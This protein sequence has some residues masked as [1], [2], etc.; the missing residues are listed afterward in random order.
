MTSPFITIAELR[1]IE[2]VLNMGGGYVLDFND[3]TFA[4]F[5]QEQGIN[6]DAPT[7]RDKGGSKANR[8][9]SFLAQTPPPRSGQLLAALLDYRQSAGGANLPP[10]TLARALAI[11][12]R[13]GGRAP[14]SLRTKPQE[15]L[16]E[17][18]LLTIVFQP[19]V[20][21]RLPGEP[22]LHA[23]LIARMHEAQRCVTHEAWL[24]AVIL[25][26]SV[27]EGLALGFGHAKPERVNRAYTEQFNKPAP[28]LQNW[29]LNEWIAV[30]TRMRAFSPNV[31]K[32][33]HAL[34]SFR[35]YI[36]P[37]EQL[38]NQFSPD[39]HTAMISFHVVQAAAEDL[40][41]FCEENPQ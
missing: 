1:V 13:L 18:A 17:D 35:N 8:L 38:A 16:T 24:A 10:D 15:P 21:A 4:A 27:L 14:S 19:E 2:P 41:R 31:E 9:R 40:V 26:G 33:A 3:R 22:A 36:H 12:E 25:S 20:F 6:I 29:K 34:R 30:L 11:V 23:A 32:F 7:Y 39:R 28:P 37:F 5:F